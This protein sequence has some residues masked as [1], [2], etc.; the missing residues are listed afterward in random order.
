[1]VT[2]SSTATTVPIPARPLTGTSQTSDYNIS[3]L[4]Q[5]RTPLA[6]PATSIQYKSSP[7][8]PNGDSHEADE[9]GTLKSRQRVTG[10]VDHPD[11]GSSP[12]TSMGSIPEDG[13]GAVRPIGGSGRRRRG[14]AAA[15]GS[16]NRLTITNISDRDAEVREAVEQEQLA[17]RLAQQTT[18]LTKAQ[19]SW[20]SAEEE[21]KKLYENA[22]AKVE[23]V[24]GSAVMT[25]QPSE[26]VSRSCLLAQ[27]PSIILF[28]V[29]AAENLPIRSCCLANSRR[30]ENPSVRQSSS[31]CKTHTR[32]RCSQPR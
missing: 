16:Q 24:Q 4:G 13:T 17:A 29:F 19:R 31:Y 7:S 9:L 20:I 12:Q 32:T 22:K 2:P 6:P 26:T 1:M 27:F 8:V 5:G 15:G 25:P 23:R 11:Y 18:P 14:S 21:K 28:A 3:T 30:G 10:T